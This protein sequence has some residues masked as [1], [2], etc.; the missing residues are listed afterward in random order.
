MST[1]RMTVAAT[2]LARMTAPSSSLAIVELLDQALELGHVLRAQFLAFREM[3]H[4]RGEAAFE[5]AV[6]QPLAL[7]LHI[8]VASHQRPVE[9]APTVLLRGDHAFLDEAGEQ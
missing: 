5:Q 6:Q 3:A 7:G 2:R 4:E 8:V 9:E 1:T